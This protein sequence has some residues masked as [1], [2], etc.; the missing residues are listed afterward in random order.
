MLL[1]EILSG[2]DIVGLA[3]LL[4]SALYE[5]VVMAPNYRANVPDSLM[6]IRQFFKV[7]TPAYFSRA[8]SP[9]AVIALAV[10]V[11][12]CWN[13]ESA[14]WWF[15]GALAALLTA[16]AI[17]YAFHYPRNKIL[18]I[19]P[20]NPDADLLRRKATEW[21]RGNLLRILIT[22]LAVICAFLGT[23]S[24]VQLPVV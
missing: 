6:H 3:M 7:T 8:V 21:G 22:V 4:G 1:Y 2:L 17:T 24:L 13:T 5:S 18:F 16:D 12:D 14:R 10:T 11:I 23:L 9:V 15:V 20:L 19:E